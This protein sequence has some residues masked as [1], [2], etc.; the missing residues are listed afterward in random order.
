MRK[1]G[2]LELKLS[3][4][5]S[6]VKEPGEGGKEP[7]GLG[8]M[9]HHTS[10]HNLA[11][12]KGVVVTPPHGD[13]ERKRGGSVQGGVASTPSP[14]GEMG[15]PL[16]SPLARVGSSPAFNKLSNGAYMK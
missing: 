12:G 14:A 8:G 15:H 16:P 10:T 5:R 6:I 11:Y 9:N 13:T 7:A 1:V 2:A 4:C 3:S